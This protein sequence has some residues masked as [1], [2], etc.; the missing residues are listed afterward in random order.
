MPIFSTPFTPAYWR[1]ALKSFRSVRGMVF[2]AL[3]VAACIVLSYC[4][5]RVTETLSISFSFLARALCALVYGPLGALLFGAVEDTLSFLISSKGA[6]YFPGY[7]LTTML[8]CFTYALFFYRTRVTVS[9]IFLAKLLTNVQNVFLG[10]L[11]SAMLYSK[12]YLYYMFRSGV[13]NLITLPI[14][15]LLLVVLL[16]ALLP[17]L[18]RA[19]IIP[20]QLGGD[21][22]LKLF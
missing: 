10:A 1:E 9:K 18:N 8:G 6:P 2:A 14:Y 21:N 4:S 22:R 20:N 11:W 16:Q 19:G 17:V 12:G 3:M 15:T 5:V 7:M 13:K